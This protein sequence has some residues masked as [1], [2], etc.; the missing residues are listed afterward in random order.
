MRFQFTI[1]AAMLVTIG[2]SVGFAWY[3]YNYRLLQRRLHAMSQIEKDSGF[4]S[5][6]S[7]NGGIPLKITDEVRRH[8]L[9]ERIYLAG[10]KLDQTTLE[11]LPSLN[12]ACFISFNSSAFADRHVG[13]LDGF[14]NLC[15][16]QLNGTLISE[17]GLQHLATQHRLIRLTLNDTSVDDIA[18]DALA[19]MKSLRKLYIHNTLISDKGLKRLQTE[20]PDCEVMR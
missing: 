9:P 19:A 15:E 2:T 10:S 16:L 4:I 18:V 8:D 14:T 7:E 3:G 12:D 17:V 6:R 1:R 13:Y 5:F 20:L 11:L